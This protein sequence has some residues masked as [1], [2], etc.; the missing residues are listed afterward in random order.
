MTGREA[1]P[2]KVLVAGCG[3]G[4]LETALAIRDAVAERAQITLLAPAATVT[5][6]PLPSGAPFV[7]EPARTIDIDRLA[8]ERGMQV[9][10]DELVTV[11]D[12]ERRALT[13]DG[14][15]IDFDA[16]VIAVGARERPPSPSQIAWGQEP[17]Q[18]QLAA[19][20]AELSA[21][22]V[23]SCAVTIPAG[24]GWQLAGYEAALILAWTASHLAPAPVSVT[25]ITSERRPAAILGR[26]AADR[27]SDALAEAGVEVLCSATA[28]DLATADNARARNVQIVTGDHAREIT[29]DRLLCVPEAFGPDVSGLP[30]TTDGFLPTSPDGRVLNSE[31]VWA[32]GDAAQRPLKHSVITAVEADNVAS[33]IIATL[34]LGEAPSVSPATLHGS[35][36]D[37]PEKRW[38]EANGGHLADGQMTTG[39]LWWPP[40]EALGRH[41]AR[42]AHM[43]DP[44]VH[45]EIRWHPNGL[46]VI[47]AEPDGN[48]AFEGLTPAIHTQTRDLLHDSQ[49]R[50]SM[51][52]RRVEHEMAATARTLDRELQ[53]L[54]HG[55]RAVI[56]Q[57]RAAGYLQSRNHAA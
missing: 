52:I 35:L 45:P 41:L 5:Y 36:V 12:D 32:L 10:L 38:W 28:L 25:V 40:E 20:F 7:R 53:E 47:V 27:V 31:R 6:R 24:A 30:R 18:S 3:Y 21:G 37:S 55:Q 14:E 54:D 56:E 22:T 23:K 57:L 26:R 49:Q 1:S 2:A 50:E 34:G 13:H 43:H 46:A 39:C 48:P 16:L 15:L 11:Q 44:A 29:V 8:A 17:D 4:G 51:A 9:V 42:W 19:L 33:S